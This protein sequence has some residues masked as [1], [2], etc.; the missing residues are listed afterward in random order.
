MKYINI[1]THH[2]QDASWYI[3]STILAMHIMAVIL[4]TEKY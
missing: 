1:H 3:V 4:L 2:A